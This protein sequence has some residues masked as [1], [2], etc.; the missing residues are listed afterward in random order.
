MRM[1][2]LIDGEIVVAGVDDEKNPLVHA[3]AER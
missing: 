1:I 2:V 3:G